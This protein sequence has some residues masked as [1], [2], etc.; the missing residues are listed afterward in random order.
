MALSQFDLLLLCLVLHG[1]DLLLL[2]FILS[3]LL[4]PSVIVLY[5][6]FV[7]LP[8][9]YYT[10]L[11]PFSMALIFCHCALSCFHCFALSHNALFVQCFVVLLLCLE[12][13]MFVLKDWVS[14]QLL[15]CT[16]IVALLL[17]INNLTRRIVPF[18]FL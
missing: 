6:F 5:S 8:F 18:M 7:L 2:C 17:I 9:C 16:V 15:T 12:D 14:L 11:Y 13:V 4:C 10:M 3:L 1:F